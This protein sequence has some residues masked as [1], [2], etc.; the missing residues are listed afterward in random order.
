MPDDFSSNWEKHLETYSR[1]TAMAIVSDF[2]QKV[3]GRVAPRATLYCGNFSTLC[4]RDNL[5]GIKITHQRVCGSALDPMLRT[6]PA[7]TK[8]NGSLHVATQEQLS[9]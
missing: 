5:I 1:Q 9:L 7:G 2:S 6:A 4:N 8:E 3:H